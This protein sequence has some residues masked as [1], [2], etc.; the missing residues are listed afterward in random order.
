MIVEIQIFRIFIS[1][2][3]YLSYQWNKTSFFRIWSHV[4]EFHTKN[5]QCKSCINRTY[6]HTLIDSV[7]TNSTT[8]SKDKGNNRI[9]GGTNCI[10]SKWLALCKKPARRRPFSNDFRALRQ[11]LWDA[12]PPRVTLSWPTTCWILLLRCESPSF[13]RPSCCE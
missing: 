5:M 8:Y 12:P 10:R 13:E 6:T 1:S 11:G 3:D 7:K 9:E 4:R 2:N